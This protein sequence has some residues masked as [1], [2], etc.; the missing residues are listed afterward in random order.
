MPGGGWHTSLRS[1]GIGPPCVILGDG[2]SRDVRDLGIPAST[3]K[4]TP[5]SHN[6]LQLVEAKVKEEV[7]LRTP[8]KRRPSELKDELNKKL[9]ET[10]Q[11][12]VRVLEQEKAARQVADQTPPPAKYRSRTPPISTPRTMMRNRRNSQAVIKTPGDEILTSDR[13]IKEHGSLRAAYSNLNSRSAPN[14]AATKLPLDSYSN[15]MKAAQVS[16]SPSP[17]IELREKL[18]ELQKQSRRLEQV[19]ISRRETHKQHLA[20]LTSDLQKEE[21]ERS[22][23]CSVL[24]SF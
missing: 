20:S 8:T 9:I 24:A 18:Q 23:L 19:L 3:G 1:P 12:Q 2:Y 22:R 17:T 11:E 14:A 4:T 6:K 15:F 5:R 21:Y 7:T 10:L 16:E 13:L